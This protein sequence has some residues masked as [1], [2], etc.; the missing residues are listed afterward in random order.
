MQ[1]HMLN[2]AGI[3]EKREEGLQRIKN[4]IKGKTKPEFQEAALLY[5]RPYKDEIPERHRT[6]KRHR[7]GEVLFICFFLTQTIYMF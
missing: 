3:H 1:E 6:S 2:E 4:K 5:R 7:G